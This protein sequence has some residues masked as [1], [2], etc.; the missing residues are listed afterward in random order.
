M[1]E[2]S[3]DGHEYPDAPGYTVMSVNPGLERSPE[4]PLLPEYMAPW[5]NGLPAGEL[6]PQIDEMA[7]FAPNTLTTPNGGPAIEF[8]E[9]LFGADQH[10]G[11]YDPVLFGSG[12]PNF[13]W[14][15]P[16]I[17]GDQPV[18]PNNQSGAAG[19]LQYPVHGT[20]P[21][22]NRVLKDGTFKAPALRNV[23]LTGPYF[24]TGSYLTL[25]QV[26]DF[27][28]R[29]GDFPLANAQS[30]DPNLVD[31]ASQAFGFGRTAGDDL[32]QISS[33]FLVGNIGDALPDTAYRYDA[34]PDT[35]HPLTPEP[36]GTTEEA[37]R[38]ALVRFLISLTDPRVKHERAPFDRPELFVP[39]D[40]EAPENTSGRAQLVALSTAAG[41]GGLCGASACFRHIEAIGSSGHA[42]PLPNFLGVLSTPGNCDAGAG[43]ISHFCP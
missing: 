29:G 34:M 37:A 10:C 13:G 6:H 32:G 1:F 35:N 36:P 28:L 38:N 16:E 41:S 2:E 21:V 42:A 5:M 23:E 43:P 26:V 15:P 11:R 9:V 27:Y 30:R 33:G 8:A 7:G 22:P 40:G 25:R 12:P 3:G 31:V 17:Y 39:I 24:H 19:N 4:E 18:C 20:W 14:G